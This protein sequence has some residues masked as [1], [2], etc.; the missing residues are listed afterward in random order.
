MEFINVIVAAVAAFAF[1]AVWYMSLAKPWMT[2]AE[3]EVGEDGR[4]ANSDDKVPYLISM[5]CLII[6][7]GMM[8]HIFALAGIEGVGKGLVAGLGIG[9]F[10]ATPWI[11]TNYSFAGKSRKLILI[12][13]GYATFGC[14]VMGIVLTLF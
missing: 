9:L 13:G 4:P 5:V 3:I 10:L 1:G 11:A 8:R 12:D 6:V 2:A 7:A 14:T